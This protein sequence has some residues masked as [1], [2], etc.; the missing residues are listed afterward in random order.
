M[1]TFYKLI[2]DGY[3]PM[4]ADKSAYGTLPTNGFRYCEPVRMASSFGW[5]V[6][7]PLELW[8]EFDGSEIQWSLD[9]GENWY[10]LADSIQ[11]P[12]FSAA[13]DDASPD[14]CKGYSPPF[15]TRTNDP[16]IVQIWTGHVAETAPDIASYVRSSVNYRYSRDF[17]VLEGVI[18]TENWFGPLF[19]NVRLLKTGSP[20]IFRNDKPFI[21][22]Q[23][24][25]LAIY[26]DLEK[27]Q[28]PKSSVGLDAVPSEKWE[29]YANTVVRRMETRE[30]LGDYAVE[31]RKAR[32][33]K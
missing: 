18:E 22:V 10:M 17:E 30:R 13:F 32:K 29:K 1:I 19:A 14:R 11:Y 6:F 12:Y 33:K 26:Q 28:E 5:Y 24:F 8:L 25:S 20:I 9:K 2:E 4:R 31:V 27:D 15:L 16:D 7:L 21:Q 3:A 23:P